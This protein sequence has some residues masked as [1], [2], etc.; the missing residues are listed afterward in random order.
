MMGASF[1]MARAMEMRQH[2]HAVRRDASQKE[3]MSLA[4][5]DFPLPEGP[6]KALMA[7]AQG[8]D[9]VG[10]GVD[11]LAPTV[12]DVSHQVSH[13]PHHQIP[14]RHGSV[15]AGHEP[16][17]AQQGAA[18]GHAEGQEGVGGEEDAVH[19]GECQKKCAKDACR[20]QIFDGQALFACCL[21][22]NPP[23]CV[24]RFDFCAGVCYTPVRVR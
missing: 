14:Q 8:Q 23:L 19:Q 7:A 18:H 12:P 2:V 4:M 22:G 24:G 11:Q 21:Y 20:H 9:E 1:I 15:Y 3:V 16:D 13:Q 10:E 6:T 5:V 17:E